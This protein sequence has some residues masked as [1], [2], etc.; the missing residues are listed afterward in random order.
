[1]SEALWTFDALLDATGGRPVGQGPA[2]V[3]GVSIDS[4][5]VR[6]GEAFFAIKGDRFDGHEF[7]ARALAAGAA[8]AVVSEAKLAGLGR[9]TGSMVVVDDV[10]RA[11]GALGRAARARS[12]ASIV[13]VT[14]SVGK[15]S[16]KEMLAHVLRAQGKV[17][18]SAAS[19]NNHWGVPLTLSRLPPDADFGVF[20]IGMNHAGEITRLTAMVRPHVALVT[21]VEPVHLEYFPSV[22]AIA[23]AKGEIFSGVVAGGAAVLNR[24]NGYFELLRNLAREAGI[25]RIAGFGVHP[26]ADARAEDVKLMPSFSEVSARIF[27]IRFDYT[28]GAPGAHIVQNSL[29]V[30]AAVALVGGDVEAAGESLAAIG[31]PQGRGAR[32]RLAVGN[33]SATLIDESYNANPASMRAAIALLGQTEPGRGGRRIAVL[34]DMLELGAGERALHAGLAEPLSGAKVDRVYL[35]GPRMAALWEAL[36]EKVRGAHRESA[37]ELLPILAEELAAGDVVMVKGSNASRLGPLVAELKERFS[38]DKDGRPDMAAR[39]GGIA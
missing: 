6:P 34:G 26:E 20:E 12:A 15:T 17:H 9:I 8:T 37:A 36:P 32:S 19:H 28:V 7:V 14:G 21:G 23:R 22:E 24:D 31:P 38:P 39:S 35:A 10:L 1:M 27:G 2:G 33:G 5:T 29:G 13:G 25:A 11:L 18:S 4:R 16:T 30:L 3:V